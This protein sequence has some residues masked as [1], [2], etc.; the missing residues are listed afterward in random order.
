MN[1]LFVCKHNIFRS[2]VAETYFNKINK[3]KNIKASSAGIIKGTNL[4]ESQKKVVRLQRKIANELFNIKI[5]GKPKS[6][7]V[8][9]LRKIDL[10]IIVANDIPISIFNNKDYVKK[11][12]QWKISDVAYKE[13]SEAMKKT[14]KSII[15]KVNKLE[16]SLR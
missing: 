7:S 13:D 6:L 11:V 10:I 8:G 12:I 16:K 3:D 2:K 5:K 9:M 15:Q 4:L 1:I 14:I